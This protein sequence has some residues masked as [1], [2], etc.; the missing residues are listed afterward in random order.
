MKVLWASCIWGS[1]Q[2]YAK[3]KALI[4][5]YLSL[6]RILALLKKIQLLCPVFGVLLNLM[7]AGVVMALSSIAVMIT[8]YRLKAKIVSLEQH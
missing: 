5:H 6:K 3:Y 2:K 4:A 7:V 1:Q 8:V